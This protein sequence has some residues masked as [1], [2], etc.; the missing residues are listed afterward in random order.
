M[1]CVEARFD[2]K[3]KYPCVGDSSVVGC[4]IFPFKIFFLFSS[5]KHKKIDTTFSCRNNKGKMKKKVTL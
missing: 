2:G 3:R 5:M 1:R 4:H